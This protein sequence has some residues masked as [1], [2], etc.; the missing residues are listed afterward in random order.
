MAEEAPRLE[1]RLARL[2]AIVA[3]L[4][5]DEIE[6]EDALALFEEGIVHLRAA[7]QV[8]RQSELRI[9]RLLQDANGMPV[10]E[11]MPA[12]GEADTHL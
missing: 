7:E 12:S 11:P 2:D 5:R 1:E 9:E 6:L 4:E 8:L 3:R 10:I